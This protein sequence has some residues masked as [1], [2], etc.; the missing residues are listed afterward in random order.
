MIVSQ[1]SRESSVTGN[2]SCETRSE[3]NNSGEK[4]LFIKPGD[5]IETRKGVRYFIQPK[6]RGSPTSD[7]CTWTIPVDDEVALFEA[8]LPTACCPGQICWAAEAGGRRLP[9]V[10]INVNRES[11]FFGKFVDGS[12][13]SK[14]HGY[15]A[16]YRRRTRDR[17]P[18][19]VLKIWVEQGLIEK[20]HIAKISGGKKCNL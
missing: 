6:H 10:G 13:I 2:V 12:A 16:D 8:A 14:W 18:I 15:P 19:C 5:T 3:L 17:P 1:L 11:L 7:S 4:T 20:H 9:T